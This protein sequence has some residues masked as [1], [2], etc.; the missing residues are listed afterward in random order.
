MFGLRNFSGHVFIG[1]IENFSFEF[2]VGILEELAVNT[3]LTNAIKIKKSL[4]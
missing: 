2:A 4:V 3:T 1:K